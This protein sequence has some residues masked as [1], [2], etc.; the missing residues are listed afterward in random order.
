MP[1]VLK[2]RRKAGEKGKTALHTNCPLRDF[3]SCSHTNAP[4]RSAPS[5]PARRGL[6]TSSPALW[7]RAVRVRKVGI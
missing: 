4:V 6:G 1:G 3:L 5:G 2:Q 7:E